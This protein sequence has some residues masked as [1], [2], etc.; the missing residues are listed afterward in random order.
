MANGEIADKYDEFFI[1]DT[2]ADNCWDDGHALRSIKN[3]I[4]YYRIPSGRNYYNYYC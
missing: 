1:L 2:S 4:G 3:E